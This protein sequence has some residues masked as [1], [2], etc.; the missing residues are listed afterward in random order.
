MCIHYINEVGM[1]RLG[2]WKRTNSYLGVNWNS[3]NQFL[4]KLFGL[5]GHSYS[6]FVYSVMKSSLAQVI[7]DKYICSLVLANF[8][9]VLLDIIF[10]LKSF[11]CSFSVQ[12][13]NN[14]VYLE[15]IREASWKMLFGLR[16][17]AGEGQWLC[18]VWQTTNWEGCIQTWNLR[19]SQHRGLCSNDVRRLI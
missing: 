17:G 2:A 12:I 18:M 16:S 3:G 7:L 4:W 5:A 11:Q 14:K 10:F 8:L 9:W 13:Q 15:L 6:L 1:L 19:L